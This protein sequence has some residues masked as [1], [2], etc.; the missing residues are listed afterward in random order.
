MDHGPTNDW[1]ETAA[2]RRLLGA[3]AQQVA[4]ALDSIFGDHLLQIGCWGPAQLFTRHARTRRSAVLAAQP[5]PGVGLVGELDCLPI[6]SDS[7]DAILLPHVLEAAEDPHALLRE[8]DRVLRPDGH[9]VILGFNP[10]GLWGLR[11][12]ASRGR[13][14]PGAQHLITEHR[15]RDWLKLLSFAAEPAAFCH[16]ALPLLGWPGRAA[17]GTRPRRLRA[18]GYQ[19]AKRLRQCRPFAA[20][21]L[22]VARKEV[23]R[24]TPVRP[25]LRRRPKLVGGLVNPTTRNAA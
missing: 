24:L 1:L 22:L 18:L 3:E 11:R 21:Y 6:A 13:F 4:Q 19:A 2:G 12:L 16:F 8:V 7:I 17:P 10:M 23:F 9:L 15:L 20:C 14:P 25:A 5:G